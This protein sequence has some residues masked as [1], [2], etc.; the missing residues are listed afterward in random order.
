L[1]GESDQLGLPIVVIDWK[2][3][4]FPALAAL[5]SPDTQGRERP[6]GEDGQ[7]QVLP[8]ACIGQREFRWGVRSFIPKWR[9]LARR[10]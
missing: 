2:P 4:N 5:A 10:R 8:Q 1:L 3:D 9:N 6:K 7:R